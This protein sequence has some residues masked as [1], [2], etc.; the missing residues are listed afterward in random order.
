MSDVRY[1]EQ[2]Y[3][4]QRVLHRVA[5]PRATRV[6]RRQ[7]R[8]PKLEP[9]GHQDEFR[10]RRLLRLGLLLRF[11]AL[12]LRRRSLFVFCRRFFL[13]HDYRRRDLTLDDGLILWDDLVVLQRQFVVAKP[14]GLQ[15]LGNEPK[16]R[17]LQHGH[18][19]ACPRIRLVDQVSAAAQ[20]QAQLQAQRA[21]SLTLQGGQ[22]GDVDV[23]SAEAQGRY[24]DSQ[25]EEDDKGEADATGTHRLTGTGP[26][27]VAGVSLPFKCVGSQDERLLLGI[28][29][30]R[31]VGLVDG[32]Q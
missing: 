1:L 26:R 13:C 16:V 11:V 15:G 24:G 32:L 30:A 21:G 20:V 19:D 2:V 25:D 5:Q 17:R 3:L 27:S 4:P 7:E 28:D 22:T 9:G 12:R 31:R 23:D 14:E 10:F 6:V 29:F 18:V 8:Q